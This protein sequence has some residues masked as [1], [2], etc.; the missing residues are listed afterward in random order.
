MSAASMFN[1][2]VSSIVAVLIQAFYHTPSAERHLFF[3][4]SSLTLVIQPAFITNS[5]FPPFSISPFVP[6]FSAR[7]TRRLAPLRV[8]FAQ[9]TK[10]QYSFFP[11]RNRQGTMFYRT[12]GLL[13][14][15]SYVHT[16]VLLRDPLPRWNSQPAQI[17][18]KLAFD[19]MGRQMDWR[20]D[21]W[22]HKTD[23]P[24]V[25]QQTL[26]TIGSAALPAY[27]LLHYISWQGKGSAD[28]VMPLRD[29]CKCFMVIYFTI[30]HTFSFLLFS[31]TRHKDVR[32]KIH[33]DQRDV[34][35]VKKITH[36]DEIDQN[37]IQKVIVSRNEKKIER[38]KQKKT[39]KVICE[40]PPAESQNSFIKK[41][42][43]TVF[44][45]L[46]IV[47]FPPFCLPTRLN[48]TS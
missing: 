22:M 37:Y 15:C 31:A 29:L 34:C 44:S 7:F 27:C 36:L 1:D 14:V 2:S 17:R 46:L 40:F 21:A 42:N 38:E 16:S 4:R 3:T 41:G 43:S 35:L 10:Y 6:R 47:Y 8:P 45:F 12:Q 28:L 39:K 18:L 9:N 5:M 32:R 13:S 11:S 20:M 30:P 48:P 25:F 19:G 24:L 26:S 33:G 23:F